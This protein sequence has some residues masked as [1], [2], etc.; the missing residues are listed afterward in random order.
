MGTT[1]RSL[2]IVVVA[3]HRNTSGGDPEEAAR[4]P[5]IARGVVSALR[6]AGHRA[7][8]LQDNPETWF[9]GSLDAVA[10]AVVDRHQHHPV[11]LLLDI[12]LEG[13][14]ANTP[15]VFC[16]VPDGDGLRS[17]TRY[18]GTDSLASNPLDRAYARAIAHGIA[19]TTGL[20][21]RDH[22][23]EPGVMSEKMTYVGADL[24]WRLAMFGY[25]APARA[26]MARL[27][28]ECGNLAADRARIDEP[29]FA[30]NVGQGVAEGIAQVLGS[31]ATIPLSWPGY[32]TLRCF[33][34]PREVSVT[35]SALNAR[36]WADLSSPV[37][38]TWPRG[39]RFRAIGWVA[40]DDV[41]G[42]PIWW[43]TGPD[44]RHWR[45]WSGG[46]ELAGEA[47]L[48]LP[49]RPTMEDA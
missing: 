19:R 27:V 5:A 18:A 3:G 42:N 9:A 22:L 13:N 44:D 28:V 20:A 10:R 8:L 26:R 12:H 29:G 34:E 38:A 6:A 4:T 2:H 41:A 30:A 33:P 43:I 24:G 37:R 14:S 25:T 1:T 48:A 40:G 11:D 47:V 35:V 49:V 21:L 7:E 36:Q 32:G 16:I 46:T 17:L 15:G 23:V 31:D 45:V 39:H